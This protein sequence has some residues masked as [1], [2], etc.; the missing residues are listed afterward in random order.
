MEIFK[1]LPTTDQIVEVGVDRLVPILTMTKLSTFKSV[2]KGQKEPKMEK[3]ARNWTMAD[4]VLVLILAQT[5]LSTFES[6]FWRFFDQFW[7][8]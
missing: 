8:F 7:L 5:K 1:K 6:K 3:I 4:H 2:K